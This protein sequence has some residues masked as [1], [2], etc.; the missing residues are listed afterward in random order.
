MARQ[1]SLGPRTEPAAVA[2]EADSV[3]AVSSELLDCVCVCVC[4]CVCQSLTEC[5]SQCGVT[6]A[7]QCVS[8]RPCVCVLSL[9]HI[10]EPTRLA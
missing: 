7:C 4:V 6:V 9:I 2:A 8:V 3:T 5:R 1:I 10:S